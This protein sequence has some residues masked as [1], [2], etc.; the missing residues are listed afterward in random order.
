MQLASSFYVNMNEAQLEEYIE[1]VDWTIVPKDL[2][3]EK[4]VNKF[5]S[6]IDLRARIWFEQLLNSM[7]ERTSREYPDKFFFFKEGKYCMDLNVSKNTLIYSDS[8]VY[9]NFLNKFGFNEYKASIFVKAIAKRYFNMNLSTIHADGERSYI[10]EQ[11]FQ[12]HQE[13]HFVDK[14]LLQGL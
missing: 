13:N 3:T 12:Y 6:I 1:F 5:P 4:L 11:Y 9:L 2:L 8:E 14:R 7:T 10:A